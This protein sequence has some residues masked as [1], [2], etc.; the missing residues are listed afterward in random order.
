MLQVYDVRQPTDTSYVCLYQVPVEEVRNFQLVGSFVGVFHKFE[1][2][3]SFWNMLEQKTIL[4]IN[5]QDQ[6]RELADELA[7]DDDDEDDLGLYGADDDHVTCVAVA[8]AS[9]TDHLLIYGT[10]SGCVFGMSVQQRCKLFSLPCPCDGA[11]AVATQR[12]VMALSILNGAKV[13][14]AYEK[15]G[16]VV[17]DFASADGTAERPGTRQKKR[18]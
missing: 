8:I 15:H 17:M 14:A 4:C 2:N 12:G 9:G 3:V 16:L 1:P 13:V 11:G 18:Q 5:I 7:D 10:K 6:M